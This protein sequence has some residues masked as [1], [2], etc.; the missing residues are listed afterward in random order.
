MIIGPNTIRMVSFPAS[1]RWT[2]ASN[3]PFTYANGLIHCSIRDVEMEIRPFLN[4]IVDTVRGRQELGRKS[5]ELVSLARFII[6]S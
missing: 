1:I 6:R 2:S 5:G 3:P 4:L